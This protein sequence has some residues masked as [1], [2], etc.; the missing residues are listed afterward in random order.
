MTI[1]RFNNF[2]IVC[3]VRIVI[4]IYKGIFIFIINY[5]IILSAF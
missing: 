5:F 1:S 2:N 4:F 3:V